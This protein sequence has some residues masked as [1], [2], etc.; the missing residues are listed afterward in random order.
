MN[1]LQLIP[2]ES[3]EVSLHSCW[4]VKGGWGPMGAVW[5]LINMIIPMSTGHNEPTFGFYDG[6]MMVLY[7]VL[8]WIIMIVP[9]VPLLWGSWLLFGML[10]YNW[11]G[12]HEYSLYNM[13]PQSGSAP[14]KLEPNTSS[15]TQYNK[16]SLVFSIGGRDCGSSSTFRGSRA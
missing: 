12:S 6:F 1:C 4:Q 8:W 3:Q 5:G 15:E 16:V 14:H 11:V 2:Q 13:F 7:M 10:G 9:N